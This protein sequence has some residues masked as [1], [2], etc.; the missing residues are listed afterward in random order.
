MAGKLIRMSTIKQVLQL[1]QNGLSNRRIAKE[2]GLYKETVNEYIRKVKDNGFDIAGLL[3]LEDPVLEAR[4]SAGN[5][6]YTE[7]RFLV[8]KEK[9]SYFEQELRRPH[10]T[11]YILWTEY[12]R[13]HPDGYGYSQFCYHLNQLKAARQPSAILEHLPGGELYVDFAGDTMSYVDR[14][15][16]EVIRV[17]IF[18]A[19]LPY[20]DYTFV[21]AVPSQTTDDFLYALSRALQHI[22]G[23]PKIVVPDNLK[24]AVI[25]ADKY[26]PDLSRVMEDFANHYGFA[27]LP[28]RP[29][30]PRDKAAVENHVK[31]TYHRVYAKL[32][33]ETFFSI[34]ELNRAI[35]DKVKDH[36][37]TRMQ[38]KNYSREEKFLAEEKQLL[39]PLPQAGFELKYYA[40]LSVSQ[41]NCIYLGRDKHYYSVHYSY[42]GR[43]VSVI[44]TRTL[45]KIYFEGSCIA[46]HPRTTGYGYTTL[47][48]H[49]CSTHQHY[50][51]RSP[52]YY[53]KQADKRSA[54]LGKLIRRNFDKEEVPERIYR[55][56]DGLLSLQRKTDPL[57][58]EKACLYALDYDLL[59]CKSL[60][61]IIENRAYEFVENNKRETTTETEKRPSHENIR[62]KDYYTNQLKT[63]SLW[64]KSNQ[65]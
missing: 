44:Y 27:V 19:C 46:T 63:S 41:N 54:A 23:S 14:D 30:Q 39:A 15:T 21:M 49:L 42:I 7:S 24:A 50:L 55:R 43:K 35:E 5:P 6:A 36:N 28:A 56:C 22:G 20:S 64:N 47:K 40:S 26:E 32:R 18:I 2:L 31:I 37:Q 62:G 29:R 25:K 4:F 60:Q 8:F 11:R 10:V 45:V 52:E 59:S 9:I 48:E 58:F 53:I 1:H 65:N 34:E 12:R 51:E 3:T 17:Q 16:G 13:E 57:V 33:N 61:K 38:Q